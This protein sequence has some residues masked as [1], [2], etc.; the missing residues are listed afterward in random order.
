MYKV[1]KKLMCVI[2][3]SGPNVKMLVALTKLPPLK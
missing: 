2:Y 3:T 1:G